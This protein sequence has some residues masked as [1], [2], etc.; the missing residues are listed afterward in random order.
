MQLS[1]DCSRLMC[2]VLYVGAS[3]GEKETEDMPEVRETVS[4]IPGSV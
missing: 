4:V 1:V 3:A 2:I